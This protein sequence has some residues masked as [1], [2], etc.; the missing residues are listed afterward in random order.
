MKLYHPYCSHLLGAVCRSTKQRKKEKS[1]SKSKTQTMD[2][3][4]MAIQVG[5]ARVGQ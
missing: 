4:D 3:L 5:G 1:K 2:I